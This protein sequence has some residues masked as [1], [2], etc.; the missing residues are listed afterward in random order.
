MSFDTGVDFIAEYGK[1]R[2]AQMFN[3]EKIT[4]SKAATNLNAFNRDDERG[5][6][7]K[8]V[9][10]PIEGRNIH[11]IQVVRT[12]IGWLCACY[13]DIKV[14]YLASTVDG[15]A[16]NKV[17]LDS[18]RYATS[19]FSHLYYWFWPKVKFHLAKLAAT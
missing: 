4:W 16:R 2:V 9:E 12:K 3:G 13:R 17:P 14:Q 15:V 5:E 1:V 7:N 19:F 18:I 8:I 6:Y 10:G 11:D